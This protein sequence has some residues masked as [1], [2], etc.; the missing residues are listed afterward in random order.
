MKRVPLPNNISNIS[1]TQS[2]CVCGRHF[3]ETINQNAYEKG[4]RKTKKLVETIESSFCKG[5]RS[6]SQV[7]TRKV[8]KDSDFEVKEKCK[9]GH[10]SSMSKSAGCDL[11]SKE[12]FL[13]RMT[14]VLA[15]NV[16]AKSS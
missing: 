13:N 12:E 5:G 3:N 11:N 16:I 15:V 7:F 2:Y 14:S 4:Y 8:T 10:C 1:T 6:E 9:H